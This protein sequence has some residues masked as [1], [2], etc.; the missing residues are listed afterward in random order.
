VLNLNYNALRDIQP[1]LSIVRLQKLFLAGNRVS[2][3]RRTAVVL[4]HL[5]AEL[6]EIDMRNNPLTVGFYTP[7]SAI[8]KVEQRIVLSNSNAPQDEDDAD[9]DT[10]AKAGQAYLL[11][12]SDKE[13][14]KVARERL[15]EDTK[16]RR[17][18]YEMLLVASCRDLHT[19]DGLEVE[20]ED[21]GRKDE[22]WDRL[23]ELGVLRQKE[24]VGNEDNE[25]LDDE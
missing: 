18:V 6:V 23:R 11:P 5:N 24:G 9:K 20:K 2:R 8:S 15:D 17:R 7:Q 14:D 16:L 19:L 3:L 1:L 21:V 4:Q 22:I 13:D 12:P 25:S 10:A